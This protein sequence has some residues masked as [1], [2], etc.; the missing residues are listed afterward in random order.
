[1]SSSVPISPPSPRSSVRRRPSALASAPHPR[2]PAPAKPGERR[3]GGFDRALDLLVRVGQRREPRL[4]LR[5]RRVDAA[6]E[7]LAAPAR[8]GA[9]VA[10]LGIREVGHGPLAE[11][12]GQQPGGG[13][14]LHGIAARRLAQARRETLGDRGQARVGR[15]VEQLERRQ[16]GGHRERVA[17]QRARLVDLSG[18]RQHA[19]QLGPAAE[20]RRRQAAADDLAHDRQ[21]AA[22]AR[23]LLRATARDAEA[24]DHLVEDQQRAGRVRPL[25][26]QLQEAVPRRHEAH[27]GRQ[28]LGED[29]RELVSLGRREERLGV[30]PRHH[31][32]ACRGT[33]G[34]PG[35]G[36]QRLCREARAG[37]REQ[38]VDVAVIGARELEHLLAA[39]GGP[40]EADGGHR[41]LG[42]RGGHAQ[43]LDALHPPHDLAGQLDLARGRRA[44]AGAVGGRRGE[45]LEHVRMGVPVDQRAPGADVVD[46]AVA[47]DVDEFGALAAGDEDRLAADRAHRAH[48]RVDAAGDHLQRTPVELGRARVGERRR[49][50][51]TLKRAC[52]PSS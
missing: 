1:M 2:P 4:E 32:G 34:H 14:D 12:H 50:E 18:R 47:V 20:R 41:G 29:R 10:G 28:R 36:R 35:T 7:Q 21:I 23:Q 31:H 49:H 13:D 52:S 42:P 17:R 11:E 8:V 25:A 19:H 16:A 30:V 22:D 9:E 26:Q 15:L 5:R 43:H 24:A 46:E 39:G 40:R 48:G 33:R 6:R 27:V 45:R 38:P 51:P 44:E 3:G 37:L